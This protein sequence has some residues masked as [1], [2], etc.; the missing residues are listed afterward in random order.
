MGKLM[1]KIIAKQINADIEATNLLPMT[2]FSSQAHHT[3]ID[4]IT[5]LVYQ[6]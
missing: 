1:E 3:A 2:Q 4:T 6:I 5:T